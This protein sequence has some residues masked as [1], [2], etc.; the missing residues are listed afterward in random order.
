[1]SRPWSRPQDH[2]AAGLRELVEHD[3]LRNS[4][5]SAPRSRPASPGRC[6]RQRHG[7]NGRSA[8]S[9]VPSRGEAVVIS[10]SC[11]ARTHRQTVSERMG[12]SRC[13]RRWPGSASSISSRNG[14]WAGVFTSCWTCREVWRKPVAA[15]ASVRTAPARPRPTGA[16]TGQRLQAVGEARDLDQVG[17]VEGRL[18]PVVGQGVGPL[19]VEAGVDGAADPAPSRAG[20]RPASSTSR[21]SRPTQRSTRVRERS[22]SPA[23]A[24]RG[25][26]PGVLEQGLGPCG[27]RRTPAPGSEGALVDPRHGVRSRIEAAAA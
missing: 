19:A 4:R 15:S 25:P 2:G 21:G 16:H 24:G 22:G 11:W 8:R 3:A 10:A 27:A 18:A 1:M 26:W 20:S 12:R 7:R 9:G 6:H 13:R 23:C 17:E 14:T 5:P